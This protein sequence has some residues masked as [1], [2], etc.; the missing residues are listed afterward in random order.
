[1][2]AAEA[3]AD[4]RSEGGGYGKGG[5]LMMYTGGGLCNGLIIA[6]VATPRAQVLP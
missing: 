4:A 3:D 1:M 2:D 6:P 5:L